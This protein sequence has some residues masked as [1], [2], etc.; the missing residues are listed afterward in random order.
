MRN[1]S[2]RP[3]GCQGVA[4]ANEVGIGPQTPLPT[5][6]FVRKGSDL[7]RDYAEFQYL[8]RQFEICMTM[9]AVKP[10]VSER[11]TSHPDYG[12]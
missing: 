11:A 7:L 9:V 6:F 8:L 2:L 4:I 5:Q 12:V 3:F 1:T 10:F